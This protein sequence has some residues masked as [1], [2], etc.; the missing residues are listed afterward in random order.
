MN[1]HIG[2]ILK[3][4]QSVIFYMFYKLKSET[5]R[6]LLNLVLHNYFS[7]KKYFFN[8]SVEFNFT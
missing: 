5:F 2:K 1:K 3:S 7:S 4:N 8:H 6:L